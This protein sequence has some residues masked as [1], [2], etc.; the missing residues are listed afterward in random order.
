ML[1]FLAVTKSN[2]L[3]YSSLEK[4]ET[5]MESLI[6]YI[7]YALLKQPWGL[8]IV[9]Y[10]QYGYP[11]NN[12]LSFYELIYLHFELSQD[13]QRNGSFNRETH[14]PAKEGSILLSVLCICNGL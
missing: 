12:N 10:L 2:S 6:G 8:S 11:G 4:T 13:F 14:G 3:P 7:Q 1:S 5:V 9:H